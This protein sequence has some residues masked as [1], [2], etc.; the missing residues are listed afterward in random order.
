MKGKKTR[1]GH[2][3]AIDPYTGLKRF[4]LR[5]VQICKI[6]GKVDAYLDD[7]HS[8]GGEVRRQENLNYY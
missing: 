5:E 2:G 1:K 6:C 3:K 8:C 4:S 7:G